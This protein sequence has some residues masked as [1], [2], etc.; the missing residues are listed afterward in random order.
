MNLD[1]KVFLKFPLG[2][3]EKQRAK[4]KNLE[5]GGESMKQKGRPLFETL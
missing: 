4:S 3:N 5:R 1:P 2:L